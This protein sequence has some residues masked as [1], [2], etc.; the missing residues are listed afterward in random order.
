MGIAWHDV[1]YG[2][3]MGMAWALCGHV[4]GMVL[5]WHRMVR[6]WHGCMACV[7]KGHGVVIAW[8]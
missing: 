3:D 4:V 8:A 5:T 7:C 6:A 2:N 1:V